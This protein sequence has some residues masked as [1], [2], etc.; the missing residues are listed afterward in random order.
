MSRERRRIL[1]GLDSSPT[2]LRGLAAAAE[3]AA[4][5]D[6]ELVGLF[7]EDDNL[8]RL[9]ELPNSF[10]IGLRSARSR[11]LDPEV[12]ARLFRQMAERARVAVVRAAERE[13]VRCSFEVA[14]GSMIGQL[15]QAMAISSGGSGELR[16]SRPQRLA[17]GGGARLL[18][19]L[20]W[21][22]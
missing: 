13:H 5:L 17:S 18:I 22:F 10:E 7:V 2:S 20:N 9:A 3:M 11:H 16:R 21:Q 4:R 6:A 1:I 15:L 12:I 14:R 19:F 8:L